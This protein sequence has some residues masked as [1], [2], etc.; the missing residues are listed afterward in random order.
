MTLWHIYCT[1]VA[2]FDLDDCSQGTAFCF[3]PDYS[4]AGQNAG[5]FNTTE[6]R[7]ASC[8]TKRSNT[9]Q[10]MKQSKKKNASAKLKKAMPASE[11]LVSG[12]ILFSKYAQSFSGATVYVRLED[13]SNADAPSKVIAEQILR[14]I[15]YKAQSKAPLAFSIHGNSVNAKASYAIRVHVDTDDDKVVSLGDYISMESYPVL[16]F[17]FPNK[18]S[19]RVQKVT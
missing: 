5:T 18:V 1:S 10:N 11:P 19:V 16:T 15:S 8:A 6:T 13:V 7:A 14:D 17:G 9:P 12:E 4:A 3:M 2:Q